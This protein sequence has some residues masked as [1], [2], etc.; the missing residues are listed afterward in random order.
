MAEIVRI[1]ISNVLTKGNDLVTE[2]KYMLRV[3]VGAKSQPVDVI[4]DT[5]SSMLVV[6]DDAYDKSADTDAETTQL[7]QTETFASGAFMAA[8]VRTQ[9]GLVDGA[10]AVVAR[11]PRGNLAVAYKYDHRMFMGADGIFGLAPAARNRAYL[12][13]FDTWDAGYRKDQL[14]LGQTADLDPYIAQL[15][16]ID[17]EQFA[18]A[19][20]R[21][22]VCMAT[23]KPAE[24][25]LNHGLFILGDGAECT[26]LYAGAVASV[27]V[28]QGTHYSANLIA[29]RIGDQ[30]IDVPPIA[31]NG[32]APTN[33]IIDS[34]AN[35]LILD[36]ATYDKVLAAFGT[37]NA[38]FSA[39]LSAGSSQGCAQT[40]IDLGA[41]PPLE[42]IMQGT[43]GAQ[44]SVA[45][46]PKHYWQFDTIK[47]GTAA[48]AL[49][50]SR[51]QLHGQS[52]LGLPL[53]CGNLVMFDRTANNGQGTIGF[54]PLT[55]LNAAGV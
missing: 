24:D 9:I 52:I 8:V 46:A 25:P 37:L 53:F 23:D 36:S 3:A 42:I 55:D 50:G 30:V 11:L 40:S 5:G 44:A 14:D 22:T 17:I 51:P 16:T 10:S 43:G 47:R 12:M 27:A 26:D 7:L 49:I 39:A 29:V 45:I 35:K 28:Q 1:P 18:F 38:N 20:Q 13:P 31:P 21:S 48:S 54:A 19:V 4:L 32:P 34:G 15:A 41:W 33:A 2:G 6:Y